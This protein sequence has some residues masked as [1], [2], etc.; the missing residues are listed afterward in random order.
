[1]SGADLRDDE[2]WVTALS[3]AAMSAPS[4]VDAMSLM[5]PFRSDK[6]RYASIDRS[7]RVA[8]GPGFFKLNRRQTDF[9][10]IHLCMHRL[11]M[12]FE[13]ADTR[14]LPMDRETMLAMDA[15]IDNQIML[16]DSVELVEGYPTSESLGL[17]PERTMEEYYDMI[18]ADAEDDSGDDGDA[19]DD[20]QAHD[21]NCPMN[22]TEDA[23]DEDGDS[24]DAND[25]HGAMG[26]GEGD[27][28]DTGSDDDGQGDTPGGDGDN[29]EE[30]DD[31]EGDGDGDGT[32]QGGDAED[33][34]QDDDSTD[35]AGGETGGGRPDD[36][37]GDGCGERNPDDVS[38]DADVQ[39]VEPPTPSEVI[40]AMKEVRRMADESSSGYSSTGT[41]DD[42]L[43]GLI[44]RNGE[45]PKTNWR[46]VLSRVAGN[47]RMRKS[48]QSVE[49]TYSK[50]NSR[51]AAFFPDIILPGMTSYQP[52]I[53]MAL[54]TSGSMGKD[55]IT[56]ALTEAQGILKAGADSTDFSAFCVDTK[57]KDMQ[58][59]DDI[60][61]LDITGGGGTDMAPAFEYV[62]TLPQYE[63]PDVFV[64]A[65]DGFV[66]WD[67][68][69][70]LLPDWDCTVIILIVN[71]NGMKRVPEWLDSAAH[72]I[73]VSD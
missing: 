53:I 31:G 26:N 33:G 73:D 64:L 19:E 59:V 35:A 52:R 11:C 66:P 65:T 22:P 30:D 16:M 28:D 48:Y 23:D 24:D 68:C 57:A 6:E 37:H 58:P 32:G 14:G 13:R 42:V 29:P 21:E 50:I 55:R 40:D 62:R 49:R 25:G 15:E 46:T 10:I 43:S 70:P 4:L 20:G 54:D 17:P 18:H 38:M 72:V 60:S 34:L 5:V 71:G 44:V 41:G 45:P 2:N 36:G 63:R 51:A 8:V 27:D 56:L 67:R 39:D 3:G 12:Q 69:R 9:L 61:K 7:W 47:A 1:M